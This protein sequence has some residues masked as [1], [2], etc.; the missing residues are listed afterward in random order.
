MRCPFCKSPLQGDGSH[1]FECWTPIEALNHQSD[2]R[3]GIVWQTGSC[4]T[5]ETARLRELLAGLLEYS[6]EQAKIT[7]DEWGV[8]RS[9]DELRN[10]GELDRRIVNTEEFLRKE[11]A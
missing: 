11:E 4:H 1:Y 10:I 6:L 3:G 5:R 8:C 2:K 7:E 9:L